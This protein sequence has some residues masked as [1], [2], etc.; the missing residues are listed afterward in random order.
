MY[1]CVQEKKEEGKESLATVVEEV[2]DEDEEEE[3]GQRSDGEQEEEDARGNALI[4]PILKR[5]AALKHVKIHLMGKDLGRLARKKAFKGRFDCVFLGQSKLLECKQEFNALLN[6]K[7][8]SLFLEN[9][10]YLPFSEQQKA[11]FVDKVSEIAAGLGW[12][13]TEKPAVGHDVFSFAFNAQ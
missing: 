8:A 7:G 11:G 6:P 12:T 10:K 5:L 4:E 2:E 1:A 3:G 13:H 9:I